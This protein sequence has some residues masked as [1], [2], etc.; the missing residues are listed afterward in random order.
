MGRLDEDLHVNGTFTCKAMAA[1]AGSI[2]AAAIAA[3][4]GIPATKLQHQHELTFGQPNTTAATE[5]RVVHVVYGTTG[6]ILAFKAGSIG[7]CAG[8]ATITVDLKKNGT[9]VLSSP[10][11]LNSGNAARVAVAGTLSGSPTLAAGDVLEVVVTATAGGGTLGTGL[12][13][14]VVLTED[15]Q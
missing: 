5:T 15:A 6:S 14:S 10:I 13:A 9:S 2:T 8:A 1:P 4:A 7:V 11:T 3:A 12:F